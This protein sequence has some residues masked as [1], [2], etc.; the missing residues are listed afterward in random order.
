MRE[1]D[2]E[3]FTG[4]EVFKLCFDRLTNY[5]HTIRGSTSQE[6]GNTWTKAQKSEE[7]CFAWRCKKGCLFRKIGEEVSSEQVT[8][9][10]I[11]CNWRVSCSTSKTLDV[12]HLCVYCSLSI[13]ILRISPDFSHTTPVQTSNY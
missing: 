9:G 6:E 5:Y 12:N 13:W 3:Y 11:S 7:A 2:H 1:D 10:W 8:E 4:G